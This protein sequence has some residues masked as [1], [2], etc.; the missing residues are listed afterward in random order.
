MK[1]F[2]V[3]HIRNWYDHLAITFY[4]AAHKYG[5][6]FAFTS[7]G[8]LDPSARKKYHKRVKSVIDLVYTKKM[9]KECGAIHA[10]T[11]SEVTEFQKFGIEPEKIFRK[12]VEI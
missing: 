3:V 1:E 9:L 8:T 4:K 5:I 2:D 7:H 6:P 12:F 11:D 10:S